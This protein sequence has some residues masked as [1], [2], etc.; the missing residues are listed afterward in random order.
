MP[1]E[2][3]P[4]APS[5]AYHSD[6]G[7]LWTNSFRPLQ[8]TVYGEGEFDPGDTIRYG[9]VYQRGIEGKFFTRETV[10]P[11]VGIN[12]GGVGVIE[13]VMLRNFI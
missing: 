7:Q 4:T 6:D 10:W 9:V 1:G 13:L 3:N 5:F 12:N 11:K 8:K 2:W